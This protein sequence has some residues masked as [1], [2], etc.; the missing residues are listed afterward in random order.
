MGF[1]RVHAMTSAIGV[2]ALVAVGALIV[3]LADGASEAD[4]DADT[5]CSIALTVDNR[6][7]NP[8]SFGPSTLGPGVSWRTPPGA[9]GETL[10]YLSYA[11][12]EAQAAFSDDGSRTVA[13]SVESEVRFEIPP[14]GRRPGAWARIG[15]QGCAASALY[16]GKQT[17][18]AECAVYNASDGAI[19]EHFVC[20]E[21]TPYQDF[22]GDNGVVFHYA[23]VGRD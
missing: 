12:V 9:P 17:Q 1:R 19:S 5:D 14:A 2:G 4:A 18:D 11:R 15:T 13:P 3:V 21:K 16:G 8:V 20:E 23:L 10:G 6:T 7:G 22:E